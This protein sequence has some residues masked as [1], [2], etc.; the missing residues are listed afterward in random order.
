MKTSKFHSGEQPTTATSTT[1]N[2]NI[3][4]PDEEIGRSQPAPSSEMPAEAKNSVS[5]PVFVGGDPVK[6]PKPVE[7]EGFWHQRNV[8]CLALVLFLA[9]ISLI[10][11]VSVDVTVS[12]GNGDA[13][14]SGCFDMTSEL[15]EAVD[16]Y[17]TDKRPDSSVASAYGWPIGNWCVSNI[18]DFSELFSPHRNQRAVNFNEDISRWDVSHAKTMRSMFAGSYDAST[19]FNQS[20]ADWDVSSVTDMS[21]IFHYAYSF[22]RPLGDWNVS[23]VTDMSYM[24]YNARTFNQKLT[25]WDV[26]S[27]MSMR[28]MFHGA[29]SFNQPLADWDVS[30]VTEM[31]YMFAAAFAFNQSLGDWNVS[32]VTTVRYIFERSGC[33]GKLEQECC[34]DACS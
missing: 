12:N 30:S 15:R 17:L 6:E 28:Q 16:L 32:S 21:S 1:T 5:K 19:S 18:Q 34:F 14:S 10:A 27:V 26:S 8:R 13:G 11:A 24:F 7:E 23:S 3:K 20:L 25:D 31:S 4:S 29:E 9:T 22:D 2:K 33:P